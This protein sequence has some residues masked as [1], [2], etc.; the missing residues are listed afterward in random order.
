[1]EVADIWPA[2]IV[3][4]GAM[5]KNKIIQS[6]EKIELFL[7]RN[8]TAI[9]ALTDA[10]KTNMVER[11]IPSKKI[12]VVINGVDLQKYQPC[13]KNMDLAKTYGI[14]ADQFVIGYI[15]THGMAHGLRN[16]INAAELCKKHPK[17]LFLFVGAGAE[18]DDLIEYA[19]TK[20]LG[21]VKFIPAQPKNIVPQCWSLCDV[22]LVH[23]KNDPVFAEV[24]PSKIFEAM[25]MHL[26]LL[27][28]SPKGEAQNI[29]QTNKVGIWVPAEDPV[30]LAEAIDFYYLNPE[31]RQ[32]DASKAYQTAPFY[33]RERQAKEML[34][35]LKK[36]LLS[37]ASIATELDYDK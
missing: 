1:L 27:L 9:V 26:P 19:K 11:R 14:A 21:N 29:I 15:G 10:F 23:L 16:V 5:R 25:A 32:T 37:S 4:V 34:A 33:S 31:A 2:S 22:A 24:I 36:V 12:T 18:R 20:N 3:G 30:K 35:V 13:S 7:Y 28:V 6:L 8:A 17:I